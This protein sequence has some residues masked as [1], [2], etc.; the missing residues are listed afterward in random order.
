MTTRDTVNPRVGGLAASLGW[1]RNDL[2]PHAD[3]TIPDA[4]TEIARQIPQQIAVDSGDERITYSDVV[5][6]SNQLANTLLD[7]AVDPS[8]PV[9]LLCGH[10][11]EPVVAMCG[12]LHAGLIGAPVDAREPADRLQR[13]V[14]ASGA[15]VVVTAREH[16][17]LARGLV[18]DGQVVVLDELDHAGTDTPTVTIP[19]DHPGLVLFTSGSTGMPKGVIIGHRDIVPR[20]LR[21][22]VRNNVT[23]GDRHAL[24]TSFGFTAAEGRIFEAFTNGATVCTYDLRTRG[25]RGLPDWVR[26]ERIAVVSFVPSTLRM[27]ADLIPPGTMDCVRKVGF[28]AEALY[29]RDVRIARPL[30]GPDTILRNSLGSTEAG[31]LARYD[32]PPDADG[33][34]GPVPV[35]TVAPDIEVRVVDEDDEPVPDGDVG[36]LVVLRWGRLALGYWNDPALTRRHFFTEPDGRRGFRTPDSGRWRDDGLLEHVSRIDSR[37]KVHG[38]MVATSEV[39]VALISL[40]EVADAAV[41]AVPADDGGT[42]LV[43]YVV[44]QRG[45][46]LSAWK[47]RRDLAGRLS[48]TSVPNAF[49]AVDALPRTVR[50]KIDRT[51]LPP[52]PPAVRR[53]PFREPAGDA[54]DLAAIYGDILGVERVGLDDDF[55]DLG[56]DSLGVVELLSAITD[57]FSVDVAASTVLDAPTVGQLGLRLSHR[58]P[59]HAS[60]LV[61][62]RSDAPGRP[63]FAVTGGGSPAIGLRALSRAMGDHN[64]AAIQPRGLEER[65]IPD[66]SIPA[67]AR[68][69][70]AA[71]RAVQPTGP[72]AVGGYSFGGLVAFEMA[73]R[74]RA[75]GEAVDLLVIFDTT[76]PTAERTITSR[77]RSRSNA[78]RAD[79]PSA[80]WRRAAVVAARSARFAARSAYAHAERRISLTSAGWLPRRGYHQYNLFLRLNTRMAREYEPSGTF[81][82]AALIVRGD[83]SDGLPAGL[84]LVPDPGHRASPDLG[85]SKL[86]TG[87]ITAVDV[88]ADHHGLMRPPAVEQVGAHVAAA[89]A[90][91]GRHDG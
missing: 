53:R 84:D 82:G 83:T 25:P 88:P 36:Q 38:A 41:I 13:L 46:A 23:V 61:M 63:F 14:A 68:R 12:V 11:V 62:L 76:A 39:E 69:N 33:Q 10:G 70:I 37:V 42:R 56:G 28:G 59:S 6:R 64:F 74:L 73:C 51:A 87:P 9:A 15:R 2:L 4:L 18:G 19:D 27:L 17:D 21:T 57:R 20:S 24:T 89:L 47:L 72:Y 40:P 65:A 55:F 85:W 26:A 75:A 45:A 29:F 91:S 78:L 60:P 50:D 44:A 31:S 8:T 49:V 16:A 30:F 3:F 66:H 5:A 22:G 58:R 80:R 67:A 90:G 35:G 43:A 52:P 71:M 7:R 77:V 32:I 34:E 79:A 1:D 54:A 48:S 86:V 81:D